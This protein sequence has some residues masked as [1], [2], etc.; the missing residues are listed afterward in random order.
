M[1]AN[2]GGVEDNQSPRIQVTNF[3]SKNQ[4]PNGGSNVASGKDDTGKRSQVRHW[5]ELSG[6]SRH[7]R[8]DKSRNQKSLDNVHVGSSDASMPRSHRRSSLPASISFGLP[9]NT[10]D[11]STQDQEKLEWI[12]QQTRHHRMVT[13]RLR[14]SSTSD[15]SSIPHSITTRTSFS[16]LSPH[17]YGS[18]PRNISSESPLEVGHNRNR[19]SKEGINQSRRVTS[20]IMAISRQDHGDNGTAIRPKSHQYPDVVEGSPQGNT[21]ESR[22]NIGMRRFSLDSSLLIYVPQRTSQSATRR[23]NSLDL[24]DNQRKP[25][26]DSL[27]VGKTPR[28]RSHSEDK[29]AHDFP[30][31]SNNYEHQ[32]VRCEYGKESETDDDKLIELHWPATKTDDSH[33][34]YGDKVGRRNSRTDEKVGGSGNRGRGRR[35]SEPFVAKHK[36]GGFLPEQIV[37]PKIISLNS[38][39][40]LD[41]MTRRKH[42]SDMHDIELGGPIPD[43]SFRLESIEVGARPLIQRSRVRKI[44]DD[45]N[46]SSVGTFRVTPLVL[47]GACSCYCISLLLVGGLGFWLHK[48]RTK[49]ELPSLTVRPSYQGASNDGGSIESKKTPPTILAPSVTPSTMPSTSSFPT[50]YPSIDITST[51]SQSFEPSLQS[52]DI[53]P[54]SPTSVPVCPDQ[55]LNSV[56][57]DE[58]NLLTFK[59]EV[60]LSSFYLGGGLLCASLDYAGVAGWIGVA[61]SMASRDPQFGLK[62]AIIGIPGIPTTTAVAR[63]GTASLGQQGNVV[64]DDIPTYINP[65]KY[66]I[67]AGGIDKEGFLGPS[68]KLLRNVEMQT[69]VNASVSIFVDPFS[70]DSISTLH[71]TRLNFIKYLQEPNE[72]RID[73]YGSNLL[74][75]AVAAVNGDGEYD[76]NPGWNSTNLILDSS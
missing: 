71:R 61:F 74:L 32:Q 51:S 2:E 73:P 24:S 3:S 18:F 56:S 50:S 41:R 55:L 54:S 47:F 43:L 58:E 70:D 29:G 48:S 5:H 64:L 25:A 16:Q 8:A 59:Y 72:V 7:G 1:L 4:M 33:H 67:P 13:K 20:P 23:V 52:S 17:P 9:N 65:A 76:G 10:S 66:L 38:E 53:P 15:G 57:L 69:L 75:F 11:P 12:H 62:E 46:L 37:V 19:F 39:Q 63:Y 30:V 21:P 40:L 31:S 35:K 36:M 42:G 34:N 27:L 28:L 26:L 44:K 60:V 6:K 68:L 22:Q 45:K 49:D 14:Q